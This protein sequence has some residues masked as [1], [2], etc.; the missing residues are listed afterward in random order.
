MCGLSHSKSK[1]SRVLVFVSAR[2]LQEAIFHFNDHIL[3]TGKNHKRK[4]HM[5]WQISIISRRIF[6]CVLAVERPLSSRGWGS[7]CKGMQAVIYDREVQSSR[8]CHSPRAWEP[9]F[10]SD[11]RTDRPGVNIV[12][13]IKSQITI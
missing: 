3:Y 8:N 5:K 11:T 13:E 9:D 12:E 2:I 7:P 10:L 6:N 4:L 1:S